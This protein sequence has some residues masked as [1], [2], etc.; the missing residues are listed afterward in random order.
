MAV[1]AALSPSSFPQSSTGRLEVSS[2]LADGFGAAA[3]PWLVTAGAPESMVTCMAGFAGD[4]HPHPGRRTATP[5]ALG[6]HW[7]FLDGHQWLAQC[8]A[9]AIRASPSAMTCCFFSSLKTLLMPREPIKASPG[10]NVPGFTYGRFL[11]DPARPVLA[12]P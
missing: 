4:G 9:R 1:T 12:D 8:A 11:G 6:K 2:V 10:V 3:G 5:A 7:L